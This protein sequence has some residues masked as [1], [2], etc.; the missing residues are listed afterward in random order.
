MSYILKAGAGGLKIHGTNWYDW[1]LVDFLGSGLSLISYR[2]NVMWKAIKRWVLTSILCLLQ[3]RLDS[4][5]LQKTGKDFYCLAWLRT[6]STRGF[7]YHWMTSPGALAI[8]L[9]TVQYAVPACGTSRSW[10]M[11]PQKRA[12]CADD[13]D[14]HFCRQ[15]VLGPWDH[16]PSA[17]AGYLTCGSLL[18]HLAP[19]VPR[20][21]SYWGTR[22]WCVYGRSLICRDVWF[23]ECWS[24]LKLKAI[25]D[26][27]WESRGRW[28]SLSISWQILPTIEIIMMSM[29]VIEQ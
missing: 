19:S 4:L 29:D 12:P 3:Q 20:S 27:E 9:K 5:C 13:L 2:I 15:L 21:G 26:P 22:R 28:L 7:K 25:Q 14:Q 11:A 24:P 6:A 10:R 18:K 8:G 23:I 16:P 17:M 1:T